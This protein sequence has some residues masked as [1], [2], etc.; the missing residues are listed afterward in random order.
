[1][2]EAVQGAWDAV[3]DFSRATHPSSVAESLQPVMSNLGTK[4][5]GGNEFIDADLA[6]GMEM[7]PIESRYDERDLS[8]YALGVGA[9][10]QP[11]DEKE[12][13]Q[14]YERNSEGFWPL[15]T[16]G[17]IPA[18]NAILGAL[19][20]GK[21]IPGLNYGLDRV[22]HGEQYMELTRPLPPAAKLRHQGKVSEIWDKG[23]HALVVF[24]VDSFDADS[25]ELL[26]KNDLSL[27]IRG[28]GGWGGERF[29]STDVTYPDRAPDAVVTEKTDASQALLYR[30]SG[31][32]NPLHVD[33]EFA[34]AFGFER[35]ILHGLC[36]FGFVGRAVVNAVM[37]G[38]P[39][40]FK[41]IKVRFVDSV[42]PGETIRTEIWKE[43][44]G[45]VL[46]RASV[47]ERNKVVLS[48]AAVELYAEVPQKKA[49]PAAAATP[50]EKAKPAEAPASLTA[51]TF[52]AISAHVAQHPELVKA[53]GN[54]YQFKIKNPDS[55]WVL[56]LKN[57]SGSVSA[58]AAPS[59]DC[60]LELSDA[61]W[62]DMTSGRADPQK[63][64]MSGKLKITGKVMA[65]QKL[66]FLKKI[67]RGAAP[68]PAPAPAAA[69]AAS[70]EPVG[71]RFL[72]RLA[73]ELSGVSLGKEPGGF[74]QIRVKDPELL[75]TV[76][77][78]RREVKQGS[79]AS[80]QA[81]V[82][83]TDE[84]LGRL[85]QGEASLQSL[86]QH[87]ELRVDGDVLAARRMAAIKL[88]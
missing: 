80:A 49:V 34:K 78:D 29:P 20:E 19:A 83:V 75:F 55:A 62:Q 14:V 50:A 1:T 61:D 32:W 23:R 31:D 13:H 33:P 44:A 77:F 85:L 28:A 57:G 72:E 11:M 16:Y 43:S 38:D 45:R 7:P 52:A 68:V 42:F 56:D 8:L 59:A 6:L 37:N 4:S 51:A 47:V 64:F 27:V 9:G 39:R 35:P 30:L 24:H 21:S 15:P 18:V 66:E 48:N 88:S 84:A 26:V 74:I 76:D 81:T 82:T 3:R 40:R 17:V 22:L 65:S 10:R 86:Y 60:T 46:V 69:P 73:R 58:G 87:G 12:L 63:L 2:P 36:T 41:S 25:G 53:V 79:A 67:E 71:P 54:L 70:R 5:L